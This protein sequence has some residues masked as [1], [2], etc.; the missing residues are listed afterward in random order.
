MT[1]TFL[2]TEDAKLLESAMSKLN[3]R[4]DV[5]DSSVRDL[6]FY[7]HKEL[8]PVLEKLNQKLNYIDT[9]EE[10]IQFLKSKK[11]KQQIIKEYTDS[12]VAS[13]NQQ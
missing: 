1:V 7:V 3:Q 13:Q 11:Y 6:S 9:K 5:L 12:L 2:T 10:E 8:G 4:A